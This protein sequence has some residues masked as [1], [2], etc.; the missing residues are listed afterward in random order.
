MRQALYLSRNLVSI[1]ILR[2]VGISTAINYIG[3][4]GFD[5]RQLPKDLSLAL[6]SHSIRPLEVVTAYAVL[7]NGGFKVD[8]YLI[9]R[10]EALDGTVLY[11]ANP[12]IACADCENTID[13][14]TEPTAQQGSEAELTMEEIIQQQAPAQD[15]HEAIVA[16]PEPILAERVVDKRTAYIID[17]MLRDVVK[18][19]T[20]RKA[21]SLGRSDLAGKTGTTNGPA[22][23]WFSGYGGGIVTTTWLGFDKN[24][25]L[26]R[27]EYGG[28]AALPVWI[29]YMRVALQGVPEVTRKR[30]EGIVSVKID[31]ETGLLARPGQ[32]NAIFEIFREELAPR[33]EASDS[34]QGSDPYESGPIPE[35][36]IF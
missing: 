22:D 3:R 4:F 8:P 23:A 30:P 15:E 29:E 27:R 12:A 28:S 17:D 26:G 19:G 20:G 14:A 6:G 1:R 9:D 33:E 25:L 31:P 32:Q 16:P 35:E 21:R 10:I 34:S 7:A 11:Q 5:P 24:E 2:S 18:R 36:D 13:P